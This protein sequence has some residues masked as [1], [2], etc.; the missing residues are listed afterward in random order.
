MKINSH[1]R[2]QLLPSLIRFAGILIL[3]IFII[4]ILSL[5]APFVLCAAALFGDLFALYLSRATIKFYKILLGHIGIYIFVGVGLSFIET[6]V[7]TSNSPTSD[8][9]VYQWSEQLSLF[10]IFYIATFISSIGYWR[11]RSWV[12]YESL[13]IFVSVVFALKGH[14]NYFLDAP[15][16]ISSLAWELGV[17]PQVI[18]I[19]IGLLVSIFIS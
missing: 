15:K 1:F 7:A 17:E 19:A 12:N 3:C 14:R 10:A 18:L 8:F 2:G 5:Q 16:S 9:S 4:R 6:M 11:F 13:L